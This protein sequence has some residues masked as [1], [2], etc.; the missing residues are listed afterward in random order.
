VW[1]YLEVSLCGKRLVAVVQLAQK[2]FPLPVCLH[3][4]LDVGA[5]GESLPTLRAWVRLFSRMTTYVCLQHVRP[6]GSSMIRG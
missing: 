4:R 5:L 3:V 1:A 2:Q 6:L